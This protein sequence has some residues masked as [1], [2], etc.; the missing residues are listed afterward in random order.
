[1]LTNAKKRKVIV[2]LYKVFNLFT[3][4][5]LLILINFSLIKNRIKK[6]INK[7]ISNEKKTII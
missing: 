1:M 4:L 3:K 2:I 6:T 5:I 7:Y